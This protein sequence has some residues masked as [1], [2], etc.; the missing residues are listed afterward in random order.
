MQE[1]ALEDKKM[2]WKS[3]SNISGQ[4][5]P[6]MS[7]LKTSEVGSISKEKDLMPYWNASCQ[8]LSERL[9]SRTETGSAGSDLICLKPLESI[10]TAKSWFSKKVHTPLKKN[11]LKTFFPSCMYSPVDFMV[12]ESILQRSKKIRIYPAKETRHLTNR[13]FGLTRYWF[14][15]AVEYLSQDGTKASLSEVR[16]IQKEEHPSWAFDSPQ[17]IR[18]HAMKDACEAVQKAK[19]KFKLTGK[20]QKVH[21]RSRKDV[22]Q[23]FGFD[24]QSL[25]K[26]FVF[27][28]KNYKWRFYATEKFDATLEGTK[29]IKECGKYFLIVPVK[30][31]VF[32]PE[33]QRKGLVALDPGVRTFITFYSETMSGKIGEGDFNKIY[34]LCLNLDS[35]YSRMSKAKC[36]Q[37]R[38]LKKA[39]ERLRMKIKNLVTDL[40]Y[41]TAHF[42]VTNFDGIFIPT[43]ETSEMVT[44]LNSKVARNMLTFAHYRF[45]EFLKCKAEQYSCK[46]FEVSEAWT[47]RTCSYC[48]KIH[49]KGSKKL[50]KCECSTTDRDLNGARGIFLRALGAPPVHLE[51]C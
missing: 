36:K 8:T 1:L 23:R 11:L 21:F 16:N 50:M 13:F 29:I 37:K 24:C 26:D 6:S 35:I 48:G 38:N 46:V 15:K 45:K 49:P 4:G 9:L 34:R 51:Y 3:K 44:K 41:K 27:S 20:F 33:N 12:S 39:S 17:R 25:N 5:T 31:P 10:S 2:T 40:H 19:K 14:N 18:E 30:Q 22:R 32:I 43:F 7:L 28:K 47:S 42:L